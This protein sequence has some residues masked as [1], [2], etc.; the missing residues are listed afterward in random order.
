MCWQKGFVIL[1]SNVDEML[2]DLGSVGKKSACVCVCMSICVCVMVGSV[3]VA[4]TQTGFRQR[5]PT[6][7]Q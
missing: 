3:V 4:E 1:I 2:R 5:A 7:T 6:P